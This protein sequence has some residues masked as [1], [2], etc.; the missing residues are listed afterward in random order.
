MPGARRNMRIVLL[1]D[2]E[3][4]FLRSP[5][6]PQRKIPLPGKKDLQTL[7]CSEDPLKKPRIPTFPPVPGFQQVHDIVADI[8]Q[9][10]VPPSARAGE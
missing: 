7:V 4:G 9:N 5:Q 3:G 6:G 1:H 8:G 10:A 2:L